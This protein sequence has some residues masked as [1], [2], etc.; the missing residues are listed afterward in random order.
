[1]QLKIHKDGMLISVLKE[2]IGYLVAVV[3]LIAITTINPAFTSPINISNILTDMS[4][5]LLFA[6]GVT[7]ILLIGS[8]DLSLG[9]M[10]SCAC[11]IFA[12][13]LEKLGWMGLI[14]GL[15]FGIL[16]GLLGGLLYVKLKIPSFI[17]TFGT[18]SL[19]QSL[20]LIIAKG[21]PQQIQKDHWVYAEWFKFKIGIIPMPFIIV[22]IIFVVLVI[23]E[24]RTKFGRALFAVGGNESAARMAG[25][26]VDGVKIVT[27]VLMGLFSAMA[28]IFFAA[29]LKSGIPTVGDSFTLTAIA[30]V[31]L[32][33]TSMSGGKG[34]LI[35][36]LAG[37]ILVILIQNGMNVIGV[38]VFWQ[39]ITF[40]CIILIALYITTDRKRRDLVVK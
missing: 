21:A 29:N 11:V 27:F 10:S 17:A 34:G 37:V 32:G 18:M 5:L 33:G 30:A 20:A 8:I 36:T 19:W 15:G 16:A 23:V 7:F 2:Y 22:M 12:V 14:L 39:K 25:L 31:A 38:D 13:T 9:A 24:K 3:L 4:A 26:N 6:I 35:R 1:M 28:G 40:G